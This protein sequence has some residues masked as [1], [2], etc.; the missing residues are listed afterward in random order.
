MAFNEKEQAIIK[1]G[2]ENG[3][4]VEEIKAA[5][6]RYRTTGS[7]A[8]PTAQPQKTQTG[9]L[10]QIGEA[11]GAGISRVQQ[12]F[13]QAQTG[14]PNPINALES[15]LRVGSGAIQTVTAP[16]APLLKP[17]QDLVGF[18]S[19]K[20]SDV[21]AVQEFAESPAGETTS[22]VA[23]DI[24]D[25][26]TIAGAAIGGRVAPRVGASVSNTAQKTASALQGISERGTTGIQQATSK[27]LDPAKIMQRVARISKQKQADFQRRAGKSVGQ[28]LVDNGIFGTIDDITSQL[29]DRF[30]KSRGAADGALERLDK[31]NPQLY[32]PTPVGSVLDELFSRETRVSSPGAKSR[33]FDRVRQLKQKFDSEGLNMTEIN[34]VKRLYERNVRVDYLKENKPEAVARATNLDSAIREW[35]FAKAEE[36]GLKN[37]PDINRETMLAKQLLDDLGKEYAGSAGNNAVTLTD[38][39]IISELDPTAIGAFLAKKGL[40]DKGIQS[41]IA[42]RLAGEPTQ[43]D[44]FPIFE[45][46]GQAIDSYGDWIRSIETTR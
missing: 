23:E 39:I 33:D 31:R 8:D 6:S 44:I 12:G 37:L 1:W 19:G 15:G 22:R 43:P 13:E 16:L 38:W 34:E 46:V 26:T 29:F 35:Q 30:Q 2:T 41:A 21:P 32:Q 5:V 36:L 20:I 4:S 17:L 9:V 40:S 27:A 10:Q 14:T 11:A 42:R 45:N 7:P 25:L 28:Y 3:K 18:I 24:A